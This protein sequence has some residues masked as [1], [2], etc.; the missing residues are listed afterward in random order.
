MAFELRKIVVVLLLVLTMF[1]GMTSALAL[2][3]E[4]TPYQINL[5][6]GLTFWRTLPEDEVLGY[7]TSG[8]Y[9]NGELL[10]TV[11][12]DDRWWWA[13][14]YFSDDA[15]TFLYVPLSGGSI[16]FYE[17]GVLTHEHEVLSLLQGG[18]DALLQPSQCDD[19]FRT[20]PQ[21]D[22]P[23]Q[24][25]YD[26]WNN[27]LRITTV[28]NVKLSFDLSTGLILPIEEAS[29]QRTAHIVLLGFGIIACVAIL[30]YL[31]KIKRTE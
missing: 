3:I 18:E 11:A 9:R 31:I 21:W 10:Y 16:R 28:E 17:Q 19:P 14:L 25:D 24:R 12:V 26:R 5:G 20:W 15:M 27:T 30:L 22:F 6:D 13:M 8:L 1:S 7:P 23:A 29:T 2:E 4:P